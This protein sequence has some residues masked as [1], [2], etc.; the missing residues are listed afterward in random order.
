MSAGG[1]S[2]CRWHASGG[3]CSSWNDDGAHDGGDLD[4]H[5]GARVHAYALDGDHGEDGADG[6]DDL[7]GDGPNGVE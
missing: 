7:N 4:G 2:L 3:G 5:G 1:R 6:D